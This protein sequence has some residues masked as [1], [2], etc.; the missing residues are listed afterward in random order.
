MRLSA[1]IIAKN[2][3]AVISDCLQS[4]SGFSEVILCDTGSADRTVELA[5]TFSNV[6]ILTDFTWVDDFALA[7][8]HALDAATGDWCM[9]ID[10][11][12]ILETPV[13]HVLEVVRQIDA[14]GHTVAKINLKHEGSGQ[15]HKGAW[16]FKRLPGVYWEGAVHEVLNRLA[17]VETNITQVYRKSP[18]HEHDPDRNLRILLKSP[19]EP[20]TR[21]YLGREYYDRK[22]YPEAIEAMRKYL[23]VA[24]WL[25][26]ICEAHLT[27]ARALW[28][29]GEGDRA[30]EAAL[31]A[32]RNNPMFKE[33]LLFTAEMHYEPWKSRWAK[34]ATVADNADVLFVRVT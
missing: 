7:R 18:S 33:A 32:V 28:M 24:T 5:S 13:E 8:N 17:T 26:E 6:R 22:Q 23:D 20:R 34:L 12:H 11:D 1:L 10:A 31:T 30:R 19:D 27:L 29:T 9:Q 4:V 14:A 15:T 3:Q 21:F 2:E 25:P 16:L